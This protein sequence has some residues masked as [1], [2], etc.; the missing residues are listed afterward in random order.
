MLKSI[1]SEFFQKTEL[2]QQEDEIQLAHIRYWLSQ[3][4]A[5]D[6]LTAILWLQ[7]WVKNKLKKN[8]KIQTLAKHYH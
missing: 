4:M 5:E 3:P 1:L 7:K 8:T 6:K 2:D